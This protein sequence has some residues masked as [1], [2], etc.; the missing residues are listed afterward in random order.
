MTNDKKWIVGVLVINVI[1]LA[2]FGSITVYIDPFFHFHAPLDEYEYPISMERYQNDGIMRNFEYDS[3]ITGTSM[4]ENFRVS[5]AD[6]LFGAD[7]IKVPFSGAPY[8]EVNEGLQRAYNAG[9]EIHYVI[10][11]LD[12][13]LLILDKDYVRED[14]TYPLYLYNECLLDD[15]NYVLNKD[16]LF[17]Q[18]WG[19]VE[20]TKTGNQT[21][22]F[23]DYANW[24]GSVVFGAENVLA[25]YV[26]GEKADSVQALS[27]E[28]ESMVIE[29]I[30]QNV[31]DLAL[32]HPETEFFL[33]FPPYSICYWDT[34][35]TN[36]QVDWRIDAEQLAIEEMLEI[37]NIKLYS[38]CNNFELVCNLDNY[39]DQAHY[40]EW[41]NSWILEWMKN[42]EG[43]LTKDNYQEYLKEIRDFYNTYDY[44][45][46]GGV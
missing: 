29:N 44:D 23:D 5:E 10:R 26:R 36:G 18:T 32:S 12:Y 6:R 35:K 25:T 34:L 33:F 39:K 27:K 40:G 43:R 11:C 45:S 15:V 13:S 8:K 28:E 37:P 24:N 46:I 4:T 2:L 38:Y 1:A 17:N 9:K 31:L 30:R 42:D 14:I 3:I 21:T 20:Y 16:V 7:F 19:V 22:S 41:V